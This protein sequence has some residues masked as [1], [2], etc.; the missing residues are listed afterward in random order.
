[1]SP[2]VH[3]AIARI[4]AKHGDE[5]LA[6]LGSDLS[7]ADLTAVLLDVA[8]R[9][10]AALTATNVLA[11]YE[12]DRF[13][14]PSPVDGRRMMETEHHAIA[15]LGAPFEVL[16][17]V[18]LS[19]LGTHSVVADVHQ[20]RVVT[21]VRGSEV[22][23]DPTN[24]LA[25]EAAVRRRALMRSSARSADWVSLASVQRV[26]RAQQVHGPMSFAHFSLLGT[27]I[28]GRDTATSCSNE[29]RRSR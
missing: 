25:L 7:G 11:Q 4:G 5:M 17:M 3:P 8:K 13:V 16:V 10:A 20:H 1:M 28:A 21:T 19:P 26:T 9:R 18:P 2:S 15:S 23:A 29:R 27:V 12:R 22:A 6:V 24:G 14:R